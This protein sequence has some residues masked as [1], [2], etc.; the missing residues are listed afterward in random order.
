MRS[1]CS[2]ELLPLKIMTRSEKRKEAES[3]R[4]NLR[5]MWLESLQESLADGLT[6]R[7]ATLK[8]EVKIHTYKKQNPQK[9]AQINLAYHEFARIMKDHIAEETAK[10]NDQS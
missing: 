5:M 10:G 8:L 1:V 9:A 6:V 7:E 4:A 3:Y 2:G